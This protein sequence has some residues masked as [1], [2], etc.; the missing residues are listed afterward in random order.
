M[1][2]LTW[3]SFNNNFIQQE[4]T[5][6]VALVFQTLFTNS[7][8]LS[9]THLYILCLICSPNDGCFC[10]QSFRKMK[11]I[12]CLINMRKKHSI[13]FQSQYNLHIVIQHS[14]T[15]LPLSPKMYRSRFFSNVCI[16]YK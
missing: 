15:T 16:S 1:T 2:S 4:W 6:V 13:P 8:N 14:N 12:F 7:T 10:H 5:T 3:S 11:V 9:V